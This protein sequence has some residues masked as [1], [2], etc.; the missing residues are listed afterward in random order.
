MIKT[1]WARSGSRSATSLDLEFPL[2]PKQEELLR[3]LN[4]TNSTN[5]GYG[6]SRGGGKSRGG[7][8]AVIMRRFDFPRSRGWIYRRTFGEVWE[9]HIDKIFRERPVFRQWYNTQTKTLT[10]PNGSDIVFKSA[11][12]RDDLFKDQGKEAQDIL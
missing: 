8:D 7:R 11:E 9:N 10:F 6:G 4:E 2:Q 1:S 3:I 5:V 12:H